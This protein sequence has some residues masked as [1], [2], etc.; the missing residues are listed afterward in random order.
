M[1][2]YLN[3]PTS[4]HTGKWILNAYILEKSNNELTRI[5]ILSS[6]FIHFTEQICID[7]KL[8]FKV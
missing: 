3:Y 8:S 7:Y 2:V 5:P 6:N 4:Y 1:S